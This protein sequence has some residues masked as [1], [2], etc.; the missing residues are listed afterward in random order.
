MNG[1]PVP[2]TTDEMTLPD[3]E[4]LLASL[5]AE[6]HAMSVRIGEVQQQILAFKAA[7][8]IGHT[9]EWNRGHAVIRGVV[10]SYRPWVGSVAYGVQRLRKDGSLGSAQVVYPY[11]KPRASAVAY[12]HEEH[13]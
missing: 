5:T 13:S 7:H 2:Q 11:D 3:L 10:R 1:K 9:I 8:K 4:A 12:I 6:R